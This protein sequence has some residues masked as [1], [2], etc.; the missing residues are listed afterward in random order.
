MADL[1]ELHRHYLRQSRWFYGIRSRLLRK[2]GIGK[3]RRVLE[4]GCGTGACTPELRRRCGGTVLSVDISSCGGTVLSVDISSEAIRY[5]SDSSGGEN[6]VVADGGD[7]PF[8][9]RAF[10]LVFT[11]MFFLWVQ[12]PP[13]VLDEV[14]RVLRAGCELIIAAEPDY[15]G[16][17]AD[18]PE[19]NPGPRLA[20]ALRKMGADPCVGRTLSAALSEARFDLEMGVHPSLFQPEELRASWEKEVAF[21]RSLGGQPPDVDSPPT[22]LFIPYFWFLARKR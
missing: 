18:P 7:L 1:A 11:Q 14:R 9:E 20:D 15:D 10:D 16:C 8:E 17:L 2:V 13:S 21:I 3:K 19:A 5:V 4:L 22:F 6:T 12:H